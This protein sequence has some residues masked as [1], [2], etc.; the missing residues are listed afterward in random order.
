MLYITRTQAGTVGLSYISTPCPKVSIV[1]KLT[2]QEKQDHYNKIRRSN[3]LASLR[4]EGFNTTL[5]DLEKPLPKMEV[6]LNR[7][8]NTSH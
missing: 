5:T 6:V 7:Y 8:R 4:L 2:F 1:S 3:C